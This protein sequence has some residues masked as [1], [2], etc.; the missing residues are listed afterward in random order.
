MDG[1]FGRLSGH[2]EHALFFHSAQALAILIFLAARLFFYF[3]R[4][5][6]GLDRIQNEFRRLSK[7]KIWFSLR[8]IFLDAS[9]DDRSQSLLMSLW[10]LNPVE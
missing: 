8:K 3:I 5:G 9:V 10:I 1:P 6:H 4:R 7:C 2:A